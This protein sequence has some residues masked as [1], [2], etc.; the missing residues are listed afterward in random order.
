L[1]PEGILN[2]NWLALNGG[3]GTWV[4]PDPLDPHLIWNDVQIG[5]LNIFDTATKQAS[6]I[7]PFPQDLNALGV[8]GQPYRFS[9]EAPIAFS[10]QDPHVM[11]FG[12]N[13]LFST[14]DRGLH[15]R[16]LSRDLTRNEPEHQHTSGGPITVE[17]AG[18]EYYD[19]I[20]S[21]GPSAA[22]GGQ[23]WVGTD[24]GIIALTRD[25][26]A[27]WQDVSVAGLAPYGRVN[28]IEP[29]HEDPAVAYA[30]IDR[31]LLG[32]RHPYLFK[33][34][35]YGRTWHSIAATLPQSDFVRVVR[36]DPRNPA[37]LYAGL[38]QGIW[39][40]LD[41]GGR[42]TSLQSDLPTA[43][44]RDLQIQP[45]ANDLIAGTHGRSL[46]ILDDVTPLQEL[47]AARAAGLYLFTP[48]TAYAFSQWHDEQA[49]YGTSP[50]LGNFA[51]ENPPYGALI[52]YYLAA[53]SHRAPTAEILASDGHVVRRFTEAG[54]LTNNAGINRFAWNL[55]EEPPVEWTS[56]PKWNQGPPDGP[57][58]VPGRYSVRLEA[59]GRVLTRNFAVQPDPRAHWTN[60][61]YGARHDF[62]AGLADEFSQVD[63][64]LN[65]LDS[66][67]GELAQRRAL[68]QARSRDREAL[69][70]IDRV[71]QAAAAIK[72]ALTS[73]P[74]ND[75]DD[76]FLADRLRERIQFVIGL[77]SLPLANGLGYG[78][79][80][81]GPP[82]PPHERAAAEV[83][84]LFQRRMSAYRSF[85]AND[86]PAL[87]RIL[88]ARGVEQI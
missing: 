49:G 34:Q 16:A 4:W 1:I 82:L 67:S 60:E 9:W 86:I 51:G 58:A 77:V 32:D 15:W 26:G 54:G 40:S 68:L 62:L 72:A 75:Q 56:A 70:A 84:A 22:A 50:P 21:I 24:D 42:W 85:L 6:E 31:H 80:Y 29:G 78:G 66:L 39:V 63:R 2:R 37:V 55:T 46:W 10:P 23:I 41:G 5:Y 7:S 38:E 19:T 3:D 14:R 33:T 25:D 87:N 76:D 28:T 43:S 27:T 47:G 73:N 35:D 57:E 53:P 18:A 20:V 8:I 30:A 52:S 61:Q 64:A 13:V 45:Q 65:R 48:R 17:G 79:P 88:A 83:H 44:V 81:L 69:L 71:A 74:Q 11:Y 12:G 36:E 59:G